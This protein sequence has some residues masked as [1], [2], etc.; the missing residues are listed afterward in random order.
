MQIHVWIRFTTQMVRHS[1]FP[2]IRNHFFWISICI[3]YKRYHF[4][5]NSLVYI[6]I[7]ILGENAFFFLPWKFWCIWIRCQCCQLCVLWENSKGFVSKKSLDLSSNVFVLYL[8]EVNINAL[9]RYMTRVRA[10][11]WTWQDMCLCAK[12][13]QPTWWQKVCIYFQAIHNQQQQ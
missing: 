11:W 4:P 3:I 6:F 7:R 5:P 12:M 2:I 1:S 10:F 13:Q 8:A 9:W